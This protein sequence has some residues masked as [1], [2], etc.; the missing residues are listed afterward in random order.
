RLEDG[1]AVEV[2]VVDAPVGLVR[3]VPELP[4]LPE[5]VDVLGEADLVDA[6]RRC[7]L[8]EALDRL[9]RVHDPFVGIAQVHVVVD[10]HPASQLSTSARSSGPDTF[11]RR[12][13]PGTTAIRPPAASTS[14]AQSLEAATS[15]ANARLRIDGSK[16]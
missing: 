1:V 12:C 7:G 10:D 2:E 11:R 8:D 4:R 15:P 13:S 3:Q 16:A 9:D 6:A 14:E 5:V